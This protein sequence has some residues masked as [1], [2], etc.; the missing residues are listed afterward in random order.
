MKTLTH[1]QRDGVFLL[2]MALVI[3][4]AFWAAQRYLDQFVDAKKI[5]ELMQDN[6][7]LRASLQTRFNKEGGKPVTHAQL[8]GLLND[9]ARTS[10]P[11]SDEA[12]S[13]PGLEGE[14]KAISAP[15]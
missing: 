4:L 13:R 12:R 7:C 2:V 5:T 10:M 15:Q 14:K 1:R 11:L 9:C 3:G 6:P 8:S